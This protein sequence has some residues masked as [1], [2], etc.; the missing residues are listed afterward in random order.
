MWFN[1]VNIGNIALSNVQIAFN[2]IPLFEQSTDHQTHRLHVFII[3][4]K[5]YVYSVNA[6]KR[7]QFNKNSKTKLSYNGN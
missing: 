7:N 1:G 2:Y 6:L 3:L 4:L 5:Q